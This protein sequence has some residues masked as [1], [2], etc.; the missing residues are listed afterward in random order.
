MIAAVQRGSLD[1]IWI[2]PNCDIG[3]LHGGVPGVSGLLVL[4]AAGHAVPPRVVEGGGV[5]RGGGQLRAAVLRGRR[6]AVDVPR[7]SGGS[8]ASLPAVV[9]MPRNRIA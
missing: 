6:G 1:F 3:G 2:L 5:R 7:L 9:S 8:A 4:G